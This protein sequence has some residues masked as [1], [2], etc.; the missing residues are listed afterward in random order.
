[1][2][3]VMTPSLDAGTPDVDRACPV[4]VADRPRALPAGR[5]IVYPSTG[6]G[7][8]RLRQ[9]RL[10]GTLSPAPRHAGAPPHARALR[11]RREPMPPA[12]VTVRV[13][14]TSANLG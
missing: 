13:P 8:Q 3:A 2:I 14:A 12:S 1:M 5:G 9:D 7:M 4:R 10:D 6:R 11:G